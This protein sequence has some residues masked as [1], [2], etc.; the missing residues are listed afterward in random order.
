MSDLLW[1]KPG[2]RVDERIQRFLAGQDIVHDRDLFAF[3]IQASQAHAEGLANIGILDQA[4]LSALQRELSALADDW[5]AGRFELDARYEDCHSAI[6]ARLIERLGDTGRKIHTGRSRNDQVLV[7]S[8]LHLRDALEQLQGHCRAIAEVALTR[9]AGDAQLP[10]PGYTHLQRA[11]V[12]SAGM[13]WSGWAEAFIDDRQLAKDSA[14]WVDANPLGSASGYGVNLPLDRDYTTQALGFSRLQVAAT[15]A[16]LSR[17][18]FELQALSALSQALLDLRRLAWDLS[19]FASAEFGFISLPAEYTTGSSL[20]PNKRNP[21]L[22]ELLRASYA[23]AAGARS[24][25]EQL[26]SLPSGYHRDLQLSKAPLLRAFSHGLDALALVPD[27]LARMQ[28]RPDAM[29]AAIEP[30]MFATDKAIELAAQGVPFREAYRQAAESPL[31]SF[32]ADPDASLRA[33]VSPGSGALLGLDVLRARL[34]A[35]G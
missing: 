18:K 5:R 10:M 34:E 20:M 8:R 27:L 2:T 33:R 32:G 12:S 23:V 9:A 25:I 15:Y 28:W 30:G 19:L 17:G 29:R 22:I 21:D 7:A 1:S 11:M 35:Q 3:D 13:W 16:Q 24:E 4:E 31:P 6:E 26:L 14:R